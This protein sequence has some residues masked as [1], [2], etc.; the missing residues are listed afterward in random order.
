L[1]IIRCNCNL[2]FV[3]DLFIYFFT[4]L[5]VVLS[6]DFVSYGYFNV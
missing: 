4:L 1:S 2:N 5:M 3:F 6:Y